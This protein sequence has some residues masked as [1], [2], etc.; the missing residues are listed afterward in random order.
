MSAGID[1]VRRVRKSPRVMHQAV[2]GVAAAALALTVSGCEYEQLDWKGPNA[3]SPVWSPDGKSI[4]YVRD[5]D[6]SNGGH[7][8]VWIVT[9][10]DGTATNVTEGPGSE[11]GP[12]FSPDGRK[13]VISSS[14]RDSHEFKSRYGV[15]LIPELYVIDLATREWTRLTRDDPTSPR[16]DV[17]ASWSPDGSKIAWIRRGGISVMT[18]DGHIRYRV[19]S[20]RLGRDPTDP[21]YDP[22][23]EIRWKHD[24][25]SLFFTAWR[26]G[27]YKN[28]VLHVVP[29]APAKG[30]PV[31][32]NVV[33]S[34]HG[35]DRLAGREVLSRSDKRSVEAYCT[36]SGCTYNQHLVIAEE[37]RRR[38]FVRTD[39]DDVEPRWSPSGGVIAFAR[40]W[41]YKERYRIYVASTLTGS[42]RAVS[43]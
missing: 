28:L 1:M 43:P 42:V 25:R 36:E 7:T 39:Y 17:G 20:K 30:R 24:G 6:E 14:D 41:Q 21:Y 35:G 31:Q 12:A 4:A 15:D 9:L 10:S 37:G 33:G 23:H 19:Y 8:D 18:A 11:W 22:P 13:L 26:E 38:E 27:N 32:P 29:D 3:H 40:G 16:I 34:T 2:V 5:Q